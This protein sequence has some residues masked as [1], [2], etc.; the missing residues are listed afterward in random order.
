MTEPKKMCC[1]HGWV[2]TSTDARGTVRPCQLHNP[3]GFKRWEEGHWHPGHEC[4]E[5]RDLA[6]GV[7]KR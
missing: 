5:C 2:T 3:A 4:S 1:D 7:K 6:K